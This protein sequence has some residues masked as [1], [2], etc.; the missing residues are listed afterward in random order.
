[1]VNDPPVMMNEI[2]WDIMQEHARCRFL[3]KGVDLINNKAQRVNYALYLI[4]SDEID[5]E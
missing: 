5:Y 1:M 4:L 2:V 3:E